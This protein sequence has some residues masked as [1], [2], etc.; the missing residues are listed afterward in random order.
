[1]SIRNDLTTL[2][3][4]VHLWAGRPTKDGAKDLLELASQIETAYFSPKPIVNMSSLELQ[5]EENSTDI[6]R[7]AARVKNLARAD[8]GALTPV[9]DILCNSYV[10]VLIALYDFAET[11]D[12]SKREELMSLI[13]ANENMP[14]NILSAARKKK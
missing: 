7:V 12:A 6:Y 9:G 13:R 2:I 3:D 10:H 11:I 4:A 1:M 14:A 5:N 8:G